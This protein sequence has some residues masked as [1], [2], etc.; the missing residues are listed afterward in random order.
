MLLQ[1]AWMEITH[2][3]KMKAQNIESVLETRSV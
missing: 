2:D 1:L 3:E